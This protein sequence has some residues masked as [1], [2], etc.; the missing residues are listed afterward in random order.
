MAEETSEEKVPVEQ[1]AN[2][3]EQ[4][5]NSTDK[6]KRKTINRQGKGILSRMWH[7]IF[8][9]GRDDFEK[10]LQYL[11]KEE[12]SVHSR[13]K[14]RAQTWRSI[15]RNLIVYSVVLEVAALVYAIMT[16]RSVDLNWKTRAVRVMPVFAVPIL[17]AAIYSTLSSYKRMRDRS[18]QKTLERL[19]AERQ[20][21]IDELK[22]R[23]NYYITQQLIQRYDTDPAAK[24]AAATVLASKL[25]AD[26]GLKI[27]VGDES[28]LDVPHG[29]SSDIDMGQSSG[30]R[31]RKT[32][33]LRSNSGGSVVSQ[34][35][36]KET[37]RM[38]D[39]SGQQF[40][41]QGQA[42]AVT[43]YQRSSASDGGWIARLAAMLVGED[44]T[45]CYALICGNCRMH[46]GK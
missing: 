19:R 25:G 37:P 13:M 29:R 27:A 17:G 23:T 6:K 8:S 46:N 3:V 4:S 35:A 28:K 11:S 20:A 41:P 34:D 15:A 5:A 33:H 42:I 31:N 9:R 26:S 30:L 24:A 16:A 39:V 43:H 44:P 18:D 45:Q 32:S 2:P 14:K 12:A 7:A 10:K 1:T 38:S 36:H 40:S 21:K 22:E